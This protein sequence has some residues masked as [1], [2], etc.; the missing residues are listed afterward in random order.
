MFILSPEQVKFDKDKLQ[1]SET[2][3]ERYVES[4]FAKVDADASGGISYDEKVEKKDMERLDLE[5]KRK[6]LTVNEIKKLDAEAERAKVDAEK[7]KRAEEAAAEKAAGKKRAFGAGMG[8]KGKGGGKGKEGEMAT[9]AT[10]PYD[11]RLPPE[12]ESEVAG[13]AAA[14]RALNT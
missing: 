14:L 1:V 11:V 6:G 7:K 10:V 4:E 8:S 12:R 9:I 5:A 2:L 3:I 13:A